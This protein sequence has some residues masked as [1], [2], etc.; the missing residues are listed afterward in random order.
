MLGRPEIYDSSA[1]DGQV[2]VRGTESGAKGTAAHDALSEG[3][4]GRPAAQSDRASEPNA[5]TTEEAIAA[6]GEAGKSQ[7]TSLDRIQSTEPVSLPLDN[8][9]SKDKVAAADTVYSYADSSQQTYT[10]QKGDNLTKIARQ[11]LGP[12]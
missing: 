8:A 3:G 7:K 4:A 5:G 12:D 6:K 1:K 9:T 11:E 10:V 2:V